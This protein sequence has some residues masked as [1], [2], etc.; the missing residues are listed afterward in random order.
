MN[1]E[2]FMRNWT[3]AQPIVASYIG[4]LVANFHEVEDILQDVSVIL[5]RK[6]SEF[7]AKGSFVAWALGIAKREVL[8]SR[9]SH[10]RSFI[11]ARPDI[12][13][14]VADT[15]AELAPELE[16]RSHALKQCVERLGHRAWELLKLR[17]EDSLHPR[18]MAERLG[19]AAGAVRTALSRTRDTLRDCIERRLTTIEK[20]A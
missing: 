20:Q 2:L 5:L 16:G 19:M 3:Q 1:D 15:Y 11:L 9:R 10:A 4:S 17:Y 7:D 8:V 18:E 13:D 14:I 12:V 6:I